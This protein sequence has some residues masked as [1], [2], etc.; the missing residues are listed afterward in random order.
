MCL[1][2]LVVV[3]II[4]IA[5]RSANDKYIFFSRH[6]SIEIAVSFEAQ[7]IILWYDS[8]RLNELFL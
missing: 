8:L 6:F 5:D 1:W 3:V 7:T 4:I 2:L